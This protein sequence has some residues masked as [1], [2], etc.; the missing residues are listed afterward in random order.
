MGFPLNGS[1]YSANDI[2]SK[3]LEPVTCAADATTVAHSVSFPTDCYLYDAA[4]RVNTLGTVGTDGYGQIKIGLFK[5]G[6]STA[7]KSLEMAL[8]EDTASAILAPALTDGC[9]KET[10]TVFTPNEPL[11]S[12]QTLIGSTYVEYW[13]ECTEDDLDNHMPLDS[14]ASTTKLYLGFTSIPLNTAGEVEFRVLLGTNKN[15]ETETLTVKFYSSGTSAFA[16]VAGATDGTATGGATMAQSGNVSFTAPTTWTTHALTGSKYATVALYW[17]E[18]TVSDT[19]SAA[20]DVEQIISMGETNI[21]ALTSAGA[22]FVGSAYPFGGFHLTM[23][24][25]LNSTLSTAATIYYWDSEDSAW[26]D[27]SATVSGITSSVA[28]DQSGY[29]YWTMPTGW[30]PR[31][32]TGVT[33]NKYWIK[34]VCDKTLSATVEVAR[35]RTCPGSN[36]V[37]RRE[38]ELDNSAN[39]VNF[40]GRYTDDSSGLVDK[41]S[42]VIATDTDQETYTNS[43]ATLCKISLNGFRTDSR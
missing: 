34:I 20:V 28:F 9:P 18:L 15:V 37:V 27:T 32:L 16:A 17:L 14:M 30:G 4:L 42:V 31:T 29:A 36:Q 8:I 21:G 35:I 10:S 26:T 7:F 24:D 11:T 6:A 41:L 5:N 40:N 1:Q 39:N 3:D 13:D 25:Q 12:V 19:L 38:F 33:G 2:I 22:V 43:S 23:T